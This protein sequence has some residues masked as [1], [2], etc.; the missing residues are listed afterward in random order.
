MA[1]A[2]LLGILV[3]APVIAVFVKYLSSDEVHYGQLR[4]EAGRKKTANESRSTMTAKQRHPH[5]T[6]TLMGG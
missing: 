4:S 6:T 1:L 2:G 5:A 3:L